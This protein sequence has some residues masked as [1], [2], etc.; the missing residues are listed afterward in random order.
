MLG[1]SGGISE[2]WQKILDELNLELITV[3]KE[4]ISDVKRALVD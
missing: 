3:P 4:K 1:K 2:T